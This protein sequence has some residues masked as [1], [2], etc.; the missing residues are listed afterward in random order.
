MLSTWE[1]LLKIRA[2]TKIVECVRTSF[3]RSPRPFTEGASQELHQIKRRRAL[4]NLRFLPPVT[5][6]PLESF[7]NCQKVTKGLGMILISQL[8]TV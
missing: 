4:T 7:S 5:T 3:L 1:T 2:S 6:G 8:K